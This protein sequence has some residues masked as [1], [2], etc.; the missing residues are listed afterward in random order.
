M[1][2]IIKV[3]FSQQDAEPFLMPLVKRMTKEEQEFPQIWEK[4]ET[5]A[6]PYISPLGGR[7]NFP[8]VLQEAELADM[9]EHG[10]KHGYYKNAFTMTEKEIR[11]LRQRIRFI[12][13]LAAW[14]RLRGIYMVNPHA[15]AALVGADFWNL[16]SSLLWE[17]PLQSC[18][19]V[20]VKRDRGPAWG[21][22]ANLDI[23]F[24][25]KTLRV[26]LLDDN[27]ETLKT[28]VFP[29]TEDISIGTSIHA[30]N[31]MSL[32]DDAAIKNTL[33]EKKTGGDWSQ[34]EFEEI[35]I[36]LN[37]V[38]YLIAEAHSPNASG[39]EF[40]AQ[41]LRS[42]RKVDQPPSFFRLGDK[43]A[44]AGHTIV[45]QWDTISGN[46][47]RWAQLVVDAEDLQDPKWELIK[48]NGKSFPRWVSPFDEIVQQVR[49]E[50][51]IGMQ[52]SASCP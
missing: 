17:L 20:F 11:D 47:N 42:L 33:K 27:G 26:T 2:D 45:S 51:L 50:D 28:Y 16:P 25:S 49:A 52:C 9:Y 31:L 44:F 24:I 13:G 8:T 35:L 14:R 4:L 15:S 30:A 43:H 7:C 22:V 40:H 36:I 29:V 41:S 48:V 38:L 37:Q 21:M 18:A 19:F 23:G 12:L 34:E 1:A 6:L 10:G 39:A 5:V 32:D 46:D 3:E